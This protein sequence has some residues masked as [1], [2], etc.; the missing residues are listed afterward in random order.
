MLKKN[1]QSNL[2][3]D[4][5]LKEQENQPCLICGKK[6]VYPHWVYIW[7]GKSGYTCDPC[8]QWFHEVG[9]YL[10]K[11]VG[12]YCDENGIVHCGWKEKF[13]SWRFDSFPEGDV[14]RAKLKGIQAIYERLYPEFEWDLGI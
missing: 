1:N 9:E 10:M 4:E 11:A 7:K 6:G 5:E 8:G 12:K 2:P 13:G 14:Q 3:T